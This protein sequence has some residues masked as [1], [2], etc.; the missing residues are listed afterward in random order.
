MEE[1]F[2][3][4]ITIIIFLHV[5]SGVVWVGGMIAMRYAAHPSFM[6]NPSARDRLTHISIALQRLFIIVIPFVITLLITAILMI[7]GYALH[8]GEFSFFAHI[9]E[10]IWSV[11]FLNLMFMIS[12]RSKASN[13]LELGNTYKAK[14]LL[15][16][17]GKF[18]VPLNIILGIIAIFLGTSLSINL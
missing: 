8:N 17:I 18:M 12:R 3:K 1:F 16:P 14:L 6:K 2:T 4:H 10:A 11:M 13:E 5:L 15:E 7:K 9:K